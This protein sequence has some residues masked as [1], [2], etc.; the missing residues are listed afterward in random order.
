MGPIPSLLVI[1]DRHAAARGGHTV[2][3]AVERAVAGGAPAVLLRDKDLPVEQRRAL[4]EQLRPIVAAAGARLLISTDVA[5]ARHLD[6]DGFHLAADD[7]SCPEAVGI[8]G[9]SCHDAD[10]VAAAR[11]EGVAYASVSP[12]A[13]TASKPG[14]GPA[15][16]V[17]G[18]EQLVAVA[19]GLPLLALGGVT[20]ANLAAW[21]HAGAHG[22]AVMGRVMAAA[23]PAE[24]V[25]V[26]LA[27]W[28]NA[29]GAADTAGIPQPSQ[30]AS[31]P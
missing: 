10:E 31:P 29:G 19:D 26:L 24:S 3:E 7:P 20:P 13:A 4:G 5:L 11:A 16:G 30:E 25:R 23:D 18:L 27:A 12:V 6:A 1:T 14:H 22:I 2:S 17:A 9:R 21:R 8:V 15:L 28:D